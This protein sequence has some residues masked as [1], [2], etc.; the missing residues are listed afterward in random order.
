VVV[1]LTPSQGEA[2]EII[3]TMRDRMPISAVLAVGGPNDDLAPA[4]IAGASGAV[5]KNTALRMGPTI[6][7]ALAQGGL[8]L[9]RR[10]GQSMLKA[11]H[12]H[13]RRSAIP[14]S[15]LDLIDALASVDSIAELSRGDALEDAARER[16]LFSLLVSLRGVRPLGAASG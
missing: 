10:A 7:H 13:P 15:Q 14:S 3:S 5:D 9:D 1:D 12:N 6:I 16:Q 8:F 11:L 2:T 4:L